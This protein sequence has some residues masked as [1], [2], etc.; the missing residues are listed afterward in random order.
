MNTID[1]DKFNVEEKDTERKLN[2]SPTKEIELQKIEKPQTEEVFEPDVKHSYLIFW[3]MCFASV[4][5]L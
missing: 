2:N 4:T 1:V 3:V 5:Q